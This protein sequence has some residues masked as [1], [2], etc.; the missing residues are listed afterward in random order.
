MLS[1]QVSPKT[2]NSGSAPI[3]TSS[4]PIW[5][6]VR[7]VT[8]A[9]PASPAWVSSAPLGLPVVPEV[10]RI[11]AVSPPA[12]ATG[13]GCAGRSAISRARSSSSTSHNR[14]ATASAA[15]RA[16]SANTGVAN[17]AAAAVLVRKNSISRA[18]SSGFIGTAI[19]PRRRMP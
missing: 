19:A 10:C 13:M 7:A 1:P 5:I 18:F 17:S 2:W 8:S 4:G 6:R 11:T 15:A 16:A 14:A 12:R 3:T 9:L